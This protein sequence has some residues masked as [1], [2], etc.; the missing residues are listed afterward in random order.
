MAVKARYIKDLPLKEN[1]ENAD[2]L[3]LEDEEGTK[4]STVKAF[5][6]KIAEEASKRVDE[7]E[8]ELA[9]TNAQLS[10]INEDLT[11]LKNQNPSVDLKPITDELA[12]LQEQ[13][14]THGEDILDIN[15]QLSELATKTGITAE[16]LD[17][18]SPNLILIPV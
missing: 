1:L 2:S 16:D 11:A 6:D 13:V 10:D 7:L 8:N 4:R 12:S 14:K 9:Q 5:K 15:A 17:G 18:E 3:L